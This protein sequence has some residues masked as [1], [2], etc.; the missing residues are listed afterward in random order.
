[1]KTISKT[2]KRSKDLF[3]EFS[4]EELSLLNIKEGDKFS[5]RETG[6]G[7]ILEKFSSLDIDLKDLSRDSLEFLVSASV[8]EDKSI[9]EIINEILEKFVDQNA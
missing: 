6:E 7:I 8:E 1:M 4:E 5:W 9:N 2:V 3:I